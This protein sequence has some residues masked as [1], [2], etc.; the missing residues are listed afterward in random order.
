MAEI[1]MLGAS[2]QRKLQY[3]QLNLKVG[4]DNV[5][6]DDEKDVF[7]FRTAEQIYAEAKPFLFETDTTM[8]FSERSEVLLGKVY[9][10]STVT[11]VDID[12][13][14]QCI[15]VTAL[16]G[17]EEKRSGMDAAQLTGSAISY[18]RKYALQGLFLLDD[19]R[20]PDASAKTAKAPKKA[21]PKPEKEEK[22]ATPEPP[23][24]EPVPAP[25]PEPVPEPQ[26]E[27]V[28]EPKKEEIP[29]PAVSGQPTED[30]LVIG[31]PSNRQEK[32]F[33]LKTMMPDDAFLEKMLRFYKVPDIDGLSDE[34]I[35]DACAKV[36]AFIL[37]K[38]KKKQSASQQTSDSALGG[39]ES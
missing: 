16:A 28:P 13:P 6:S 29:Q 22:P 30:K 5:N 7:R 17:I 26:P 15:Q 4:K 37:K 36:S 10:S 24:P 27:P 31:I 34:Q 21:D 20:D 8:Y 1:K 33:E 32:L 9:V 23:A 25:Q 14:S 3:I 35:D 18:A 2:I 12:N 19:N 11:F 39:G 38:S